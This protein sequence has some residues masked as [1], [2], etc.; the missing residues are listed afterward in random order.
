MKKINLILCA[1]AVTCA[2]FFVSCSNSASEYTFVNETTT[3]NLY[4]VT[5]TYTKIEADSTV[6]SGVA[7]TADETETTVKTITKGYATISWTDSETLKGNVS[8]EYTISF[9]GLKGT[10]QSKTDV[11]TTAG[12]LA[13][14]NPT[15]GSLNLSSISLRKIDDVFCVFT[16]DGQAVKVSADNL[17]SGEDFT[18]T[19]EYSEV[20]DNLGYRLT[21]NTDVDTTKT[22]KKY[23]LKF[24]AAKGL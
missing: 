16:E 13:P 20:E 6:T 12:T 15:E 18:L 5:G 9:D 19:I 1:A 23:D 8:N 10:T 14:A 3:R 21:T 17:E 11:G 7:G 24:V 22:T 2:A 4:S